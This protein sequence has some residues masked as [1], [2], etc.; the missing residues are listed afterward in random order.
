MNRKAHVACNL[1]YLFE[2]EG[3]LKV[4]ARHV[5]CKCGN[6]SETVPDKVVVA[7]ADY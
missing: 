4:T 6:N 7:N 3:L 2:Y 5:R 1:N